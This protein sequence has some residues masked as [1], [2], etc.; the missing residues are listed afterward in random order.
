[1]ISDHTFGRNVTD[2]TGVW[3]GTKWLVVGFLP[4]LPV[5]LGFLA[6]FLG[7][8]HWLWTGGLILIGLILLGCFCPVEQDIFA[9]SAL[10]WLRVGYVL[11]VGGVWLFFGLSHTGSMVYV[12]NGTDKILIVE[13]D[14]QPWLTIPP[15]GS[16]KTRLRQMS[17]QMVTRSEEGMQLDSR[18]LKVERTA[19]ILNLLGA[20]TYHRGTAEYSADGHRP[21]P[22]FGF[23]PEDVTAVW[24][25]ANVD[26]LFEVPPPSISVR[27]PERWARRSFLLRGAA[28]KDTTR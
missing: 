25:E 11:L 21:L 13:L 1:M 6:A 24:I 2:P 19:Y 7:S 9:M 15:N 28:P 10:G 20:R 17:Y 16:I 14:G 27:A 26:Y 18:R 5:G 8:D 22:G 23:L 12:E 4:I 3:S